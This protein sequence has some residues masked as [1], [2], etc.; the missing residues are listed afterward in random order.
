MI[1][2]EEFEVDMSGNFKEDN[3]LAS[4]SSIHG[5]SHRMLD[6]SHHGESIKG[7][8]NHSST[9]RNK[10]VFNSASQNR[11]KNLIEVPEKYRKM[12]EGLKDDKIEIADFTG[13]ELGDSKLIL[14]CEYIAKS[15]KLRSLKLNKNK[16]TD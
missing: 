16:I 9:D 2:L 11:K 7:F 3:F 1:S 4:A 10:S 14:L 12:V 6:F 15:S 13:A 8:A 5:E